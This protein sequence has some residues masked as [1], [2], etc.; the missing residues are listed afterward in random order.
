MERRRKNAQIILFYGFFLIISPRQEKIRGTIKTHHVNRP[1]GMGNLKKQHRLLFVNV[2][3]N[4]YLT[5]EI[6]EATKH[7]GE[8]KHLGPTR[9]VSSVASSSSANKSNISGY[10]LAQA[11]PR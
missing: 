4:V 3:R 9:N 6:K 1:L 11:R 7:H 2:S 5:L 8:N 10:N